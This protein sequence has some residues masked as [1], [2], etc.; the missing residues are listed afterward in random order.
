MKNVIFLVGGPGSGK[1]IIIK[2]SLVNRNVKEY[3]IEQIKNIKLFEENV[4][5]TANAYSF[6][7]IKEAQKLFENLNYNTFMIYVDVSNSISKE[8]LSNR[9]IDENLR[10]TRLIESKEN[11]NKFKVI[12]ETVYIFDN[13]YL[14]ESTEIQDQ[15]QKINK[16]LD[17]EIF[18][19]NL[20]LFAEIDIDPFINKFRNKLFEETNGLYN[21][22]KQD[23]ETKKVK[24]SDTQKVIGNLIPK[25][26]LTQTFDTRE[27]GDTN[28]IQTY[29]FAKEAID[30]PNPIDTGMMGGVQ[31]SPQVGDDI[32]N[33]HGYVFSQKKNPNRMKNFEKD[34]DV[35]RTKQLPTR[36]KKILF[37]G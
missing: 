5:V 37:K 16:Q 19:N 33:H 11:L 32:Q 18:S 36:I 28:L 4:V 22:F 27:T 3:N 31:N 7:K 30:S 21:K 12:F 10:I 9:D 6:D 2:E 14:L 26:G 35:N 23:K 29:T 8:R 15:L 25:T 13:S 20:E 1:D 24:K 34:Q 17:I